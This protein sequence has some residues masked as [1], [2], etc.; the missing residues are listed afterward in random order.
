MIKIWDYETCSKAGEVL[1]TVVGVGKSVVVP[2]P[3]HAETFELI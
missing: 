1:L 2:K 3:E